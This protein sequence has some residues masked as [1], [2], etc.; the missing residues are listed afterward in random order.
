MERLHRR[1]F[2]DAL[3]GAPGGEAPRGVHIGAAGMIVVNLSGKK[4]QDAL[5]GF[6]CGRKEWRRL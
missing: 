1:E 4:F 2:I 5:C 3:A 6:R